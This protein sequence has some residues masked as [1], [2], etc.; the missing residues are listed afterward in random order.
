MIIC[1]EFT[2][3]IQLLPNIILM[4]LQLSSCNPDSIDAFWSFFEWFIARLSL[5]LISSVDVFV[6][7]DI[8]FC[9]VLDISIC[10]SSL[11]FLYDR[12]PSRL[13]W[14]VLSMMS[15]S[16]MPLWYNLLAVVARNEWFVL[17]PLIPAFEQR[18]TIILLSV[19]CPIGCFEYHTP[20]VEIFCRGLK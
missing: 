15:C 1:V 17:N 14:P 20:S 16:S 2:I 5:F 11:V 6:A 13:L 4:W 9:N 8:L 10:W 7:V 18:F 19:L 12:T 3:I